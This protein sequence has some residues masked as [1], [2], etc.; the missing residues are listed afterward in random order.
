MGPLHASWANRNSNKA[1]ALLTHAKALCAPRAALVSE[2]E[3]HG[4]GEFTF[5]DG[6]RYQTL[7]PVHLPPLPPLPRAR[8]SLL[9][10]CLRFPLKHTSV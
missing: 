7:A 3:M 10:A 6:K 4:K 1:F 5:P 2:G 8:L 9:S